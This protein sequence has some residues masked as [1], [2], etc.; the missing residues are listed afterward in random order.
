MV[1]PWVRFTQGT[2][3]IKIFC[4]PYSGGT[5]QLFQVLARMVPPGLGVYALEMPGRG[6][7]F[8]DKPPDFLSSLVNEAIGG[9]RLLLEGKDYILF[10]H[11]LG[12]LVAFET[13][14]EL[15]RRSLR[16]PKHLFVSGVRAPNVPR[17]EEITYA[18]PHNEFIRK[19]KQMGGT[20]D[21]VLENKELLELM[22]P[23]LR[24]DFKLYETYIYKVEKPL[25][26]PITAFG[27]TL[28]EYVIQADIEGWSEHTMSIFSRYM[29][30][31]GH[32]FIH[33]HFKDIFDIMMKT[34]TL[35]RP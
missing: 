27:G 26:C 18:L 7:R 1:Q 20:P 29:F 24:H 22:V 21:E 3:T 17:R 4:F 14:R 10:G 28:D 8:R 23:I 2:D 16:L 6:R 5:A 11:S 33:N 34:L 19:L 32:F 35:Y 12:G 31:D 30:E 25:E 13:V 15:R 9:M